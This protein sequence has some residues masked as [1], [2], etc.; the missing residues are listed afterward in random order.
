MDKTMAG[1]ARPAIVLSM[2]ALCLYN[3]DQV[4]YQQYDQ[5][6]DQDA[7]GGIGVVAS[8]ERP[9]KKCDQKQYRQNNQYNDHVRNLLFTIRPLS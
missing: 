5:N 1:R 7:G 2:L 8:S 9:V 6:N 3:P 4:Q